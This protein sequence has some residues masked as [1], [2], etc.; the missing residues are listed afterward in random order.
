MSRK[1][2]AKG[3]SLVQQ[4]VAKIVSSKKIKLFVDQNN[5]PYIAPFVDGNKV[6][7]LDSQDAM[8]WLCG[9]VM[10][11][12]NNSVLLRDEPKG[13]I[14]SLRG[15][16]K[17]RG[18]GKVHLDLRTC[19]DDDG[20]IW[21]DLG[22][23]A[24]KISADGWQIVHNPPILFARNYSQQEQ[25]LPE[26]GGDIWEIFD[27]IN[28]KN[29][30]DRL[31]LISFLVASLVPGI[32]KPILAISGPAGSGKSECTK[33][34]KMLMDPTT[35][36]SMPPITSVDELNKLALTSAVMAFDNLSSMKDS[37]AN[38]FCRL[39]TG[40]GVRIR[41]LYKT[42]EY[43]TF[44]A[45]RPLIVNGISQI[46]TQSDLLNRAIPVELS[47]ILK[48][49]T[50]DE[51]RSSFD[52]ARP[53]L[54]GAMFDLLSKAI[55]IYPSIARTEWPRMGAFARWSYA[56]CEAL[57]GDINGESFMSAYA[58]VEKIQHHEALQA[59]PFTEAVERAMKDSDAWIGTAA[60]L[61]EKVTR[62]IESDKSPDGLKFL[63]KS[64]YWPSNPRSVSVNLR[65]A[66]SDFRALGLYVFTPRSTER[67]FI[68]INSNLPCCKACEALLDIKT[69]DG[70]T[71]AEMGYTLK[72]L[73]DASPLTISSDL[74]DFDNQNGIRLITDFSNGL[75]KVAAKVLFKIMANPIAELG[76]QEMD[77][78]EATKL[79]F[80]GTWGNS[81]IYNSLRKTEKRIEIEQKKLERNRRK[82]EQAKIEQEERAKRLHR[83]EIIREKKLKRKQE[84]YVADCKKKGI[85]VD[86]DEYD[87][88]GCPF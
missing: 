21:Y 59:N 86:K 7:E 38:Q 12:F 62:M 69:I 67:N 74:L 56:V 55:E 54:L 33:T 5:D 63:L 36:P 27:Y 71:F 84:E 6:Y 70:P 34:L 2:I 78:M 29:P 88:I 48:R 31:L 46:I 25:V 1:K 11:N 41:K 68:I 51:L 80:S 43:I 30:N 65:K 13:V 16:A 32:N 44:E 28:V 3:V 85:P 14:D 53:R 79:L 66:V 35:P 22:A 73:I 15:Y 42:N 23:S 39:A 20:N 18:L 52:S 37:V 8:D 61:L 49:I 26:K 76:Y 24:V 17:V 75:D 81:L 64:P 19:T 57:G 82:Q 77:A 47:P 45:I 9:Y 4:V 72:E 50:D 58:E 60:E 40:T 83:E 87:Y 10:D